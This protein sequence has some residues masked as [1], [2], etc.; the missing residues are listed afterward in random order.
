MGGRRRKRDGAAPAAPHIEVSP[1]MPR[2]FEDDY[3]G[4][5][6]RAGHDAGPGTGY[7]TDYG[8][9]HGAGHGDIDHGFGDGADLDAYLAPGAVDPAGPADPAGV[10]VPA[11]REAPDGDTVAGGRSARRTP[12]VPIWHPPGMPSALLTAG[13]AVLLAVAAL[14]GGPAPLLGAGVLQVVT[15]A[16]WF[17]L[18]G[19]WPARQ[20]IALA[21][22]SGFAA[23]VAVQIAG[24][25]G[26]RVLPG[27]LAGA[28]LLVLAQQLARRDG[29]GEL[30]PALAVTAS[31]TL[32]TVLDV[33]YVFAADLERPGVD[34]G[35]VVLAGVAAVAAAVF[36]AS[37]PLPATAGAVAGFLVGT[38]VGAGV[39]MAQG[40]GG[41][42]ALF[43]AGA[44]VAGLAGRA[45][46]GYDHPSRFVHLTAGVALP[47]AFAG[48][49]IYLLGRVVVG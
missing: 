35:A 16:G 37:A 4:G 20:G 14:A 46:S 43:A 21:A 33:A 3:D 15:A 39:G 48:P 45:A 18:N 31:A 28:V 12:S 19:M 36:V 1:G 7:G 11:P 47:L 2:R 42:A 22:V 23:L 25:D 29:R 41:N 9:G 26:L 34:T 24:D 10:T 30:L 13:L 5:H 6:A 17:R 40:I 38:A 8:T 44:A 49:V 27:V 32:V